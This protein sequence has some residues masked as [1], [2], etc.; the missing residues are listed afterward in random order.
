[1]SNFVHLHLH[2]QY[3]ILDGASKIS[4]VM[5][6]CR[7]L[8]MPAVAITD[9]GNMF[10]VKEFHNHA[11]ANGIKPIIGCETYVAKRSISNTNEKHD[12]SGDHM[13]LLAKNHT[14]YRNL[15]TLISK[16]WTE[17][18]YYKPR[19][20][21]ELLRKHH[22]G[23]IATTACIAGEIPSA[24]LNGDMESAENTIREF[25]EI[26]G[27]DFYLE[28]QRH[29]TGQPVFDSDTLDKQ[30]RV[31]AAYRQLSKQFG[32]KIIASNDVHF[33]N[34]QDA[35]AHDRLICLNTGKDLDDPERLRYT[36]QE[37]FKSEQEMRDLFSDF[38]E[39]IDNTME[40]AA[41]VEDYD[42]DHA[43]IMPEF[44]LPD[45][46]SDKDEYLRHLAFNGA[47]KRWNPLTDE[48]RERLDFE[49]GTIKK[50]GYP[51]YFLIVQD[52]LNAARDMGVS[53][54]P[55]RGSAAGSAVAYSLKITDIDPIRYNLLF[56]RFLNPDRISMP[57]IDIDFDED[58]RELVLDYVVNKYGHD[59][60]AHIIT[61]GTMAAKMAI[62]DVARVQ[63]L[64]LPD[65]DRLAKLIPERPGT[66]FAKA[67]DEVPELAKE[68]TNG[69]PLIAQTLQYAEA[70]E[71]S[72]RQT[73]VH[74]CGIIIGRDPLYEHIPI[75]TAKDTNLWVTQFDGN[76]VESV[77]LLK[78]D[79]LGLKTLSIIKDAV[80]NI[81]LSKGIE[82]DIDNIPLEDELTFQLYSKGETTG[83]FQFES[84]GMKKYLRDLK[85]NRFEDL[86]A[87]NA[88]YRPG[89]MEYIPKFI[90]RKH[91]Q[92]EIDYPLPV[93]EKHLKDTYGITVYQ[94]QV[95]L[96]SQDLAGFSKG[97]ADSLRKAMGKKKRDLMDKMKVKFI[98]GCE[99]NGHDKKIVDQ[100][101]SD[102]EAFAEYAFNKSHST[103]YAY[104]SYQTAYLKAHYPADFMAA[105]LSRNISDIKKLTTFM[106]ETRRMGTE[107]LGP[108]VNES[109][110]RFMVNNEG[111]IR[112]GLGAIKGVGEAAIISMIEERQ[113]G[114]PFKDIY[115]FAERVNLNSL[116]KKSIEAMAV[117][118]AFDCFEGITRSM[119]FAEN[120]KGE[121]FI[122]SL[123]RYGNRV[124]SELQTSQQ[125]LFGDDSAGFEV[126]RPAPPETPEWPKLEKLTRE[127]DV[128]GIFL[129]AHPLDDYRLELETFCNVAL[130]ELSDLNPLLNRDITIA[131]MVTEAR[132]GTAKNGKPFGSLT[133]QDYTDSYRLM[134]FDRDYVDNSKYFTPGYF[135]LIK[136]K[137]QKRKYRE[138]E[139][140]VK[141]YSIS[142]LTS[143]KDELMKK[144]TLKIDIDSVTGALAGR[145]RELAENNPG[146]TELSVIVYEPATRIWISLFSRPYRV[147]LNNDFIRFLTNHRGIDYKVN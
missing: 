12:R 89:P 120:A 14:G 114:G 117:A 2:T 1:M 125:S 65:A 40:I 21:K 10:G 95:M 138:D 98:E 143:V 53:V 112:F 87:M 67:F 51:G 15:V 73:G 7:E 31:F 29:K 102:W 133:I 74:A 62:R 36:K 130:S 144:I 111:N 4:G 66:T 42:L 136:G 9:H 3:S 92:E 126:V 5:K 139:V 83:L 106:D 115:D 107:V 49:L 68:R 60:V 142:L 72:V 116:N 26:F 132:S 84:D 43:P 64:P 32:I 8:G 46:F 41:A 11:R 75:S 108:D 124:K 22:E 123:I 110:V 105:V 147:R 69:T 141:V 57:D 6:I 50:M 99:T 16:S 79:F 24:I 113:S 82:I 78:M 63:K 48:I 27:S 34:E 127:K 135:L 100:I 76:H 122:E 38:P 85:P 93:M 45:G 61:F 44:P 134:M 119:F 55:G 35:E 30:N 54:G 52:F 96:L 25:Q 109:G 28:V 81:R 140:E 104:V 19:I 94:E 128:I 103:C 88:L 20:D 145:L 121:S 77:G 58:G 33:L 59:R 91:G 47:A 118:G 71:G 39:V 37:Y 17:G 97:E 70:L 80:D 56:E 129:S 137:V 101:W 86:I 131:G 90:R 23:L 18:F 146:N 13:I